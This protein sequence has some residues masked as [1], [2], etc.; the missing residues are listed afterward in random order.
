MKN[1]DLVYLAGDSL[2]VNVP[3][4]PYHDVICS[5]LGDFS[6]AIQRNSRAAAFPDILSFAF[7]CRK[8]NIVKLK[9][10]Y[11][12]VDSR[13]GRGIVF[14]IAPSNVPINFAFSYVFGLLSGNSNIVRV[15]SKQYKQVEIICDILNEM[16]ASGNYDEI[17]K[18]TAVVSYE[19]DKTITDFLSA[20]CDSRVIWGG[21][22]SIQEIRKSPLKMR[23][24]EITFADRFSLAIIDSDAISLLSDD[25]LEKLVAK[26]YN[27]TYLMDQNACSSPHCILWKKKSDNLEIVKKRF[28][29]FVFKCA[30][31]KYDLASI[32]VSDKYVLLCKYAMQSELV[33]K[34]SRYENMLYVMTLMHLPED[35]TELR[36]RFG[37]FFEYE[38]WDYCELVNSINNKVQTCVY[39]GI[40]KGDIKKLIIDNGLTGIDRVVPMGSALDIG[41]MWD[42]YDIVGTLSRVINVV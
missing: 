6:K 38:I 23:S 31:Q 34:I 39:H 11:K 22:L 19:K 5:F 21:D 4:P 32:K 9:L 36:G 1:I 29:E 14:H 12:E 13:L 41:I 16:F 26:F 25:E 20:L 40:D 35:F 42:G 37:L 3:L 30:L 27:D 24:I 10:G 7:F 18:R 28:W 17:K 2:P 8:A 15:S 33:K